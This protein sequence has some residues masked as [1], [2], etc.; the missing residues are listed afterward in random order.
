MTRD[1]AAHRLDRKVLVAVERLGRALRSA[2]QQA[3]TRHGLSRLGLD[4][5]ETLS[6]GRAR[7][8]GELAAELG[9]SQPT[10]SDAIATLDQRGLLSRRSDPT[11]RRSALVS[12]SDEGTTLSAEI[13]RDLAALREAEA[14]SPADR[15]TTLHVLLGEIERLH[16]AG[17]ITVDRSCLTCRHYHASREETALCRL[18]DAPLDLADLRVDCPEHQHRG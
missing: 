9:L 2:R 5:V 14:G 17:V 15:A 1:E 18:L 6:D 7:R 16:R 11:D 3:A 10:L 12:L 4:V 8:V 13:D